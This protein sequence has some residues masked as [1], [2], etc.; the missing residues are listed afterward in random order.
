M[1]IERRVADAVRSAERSIGGQSIQ[2]FAGNLHAVNDSAASSSPPQTFD[3]GGDLSAATERVTIGR[4]TLEI[5]IADGMVGGAPGHGH[6][7]VGFVRL[8]GR[9]A[10]N[11]QQCARC[12]PKRGRFSSTRAGTLIDGLTT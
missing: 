1:E 3:P 8:S 9:Q 4:T 10:S 12:E 5:Q 11:P 2:N 7:L 6:P